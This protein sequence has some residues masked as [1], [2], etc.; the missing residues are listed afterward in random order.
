MDNK[1]FY[2]FLLK[3][4]AIA[5][6]GLLFSKDEYA[7]ENYHQ[8]NN[9][10]LAMLESFLDVK[11]DRPNYFKCDVYP[12]PNVSV[13]TAVFNELGH[14]LLVKESKTGTY[15]LPGGWCDLYDSPSEAAKAEVSQ[16][17]GLEVEIVRLVGVINHTPFVSSSTTPEYVIVFE[18]RGAGAFHN[19]THETTEVGYFPLDGLPE[20]SHKIKEHEFQRIVQ[21][22]KKGETIFD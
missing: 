22:I 6:T 20:L 5:K 13:R 11:F 14:I 8:I 3:V 4:Q 12:T 10:T 21:A 16:E 18:G 2:D 17:A 7:I 1:Y 9:L 15:S 19:H